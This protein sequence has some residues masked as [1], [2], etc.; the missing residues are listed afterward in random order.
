MSKRMMSDSQ[1]DSGLKS[2][3][4]HRRKIRAIIEQECDGSRMSSTKWKEMLN[5]LWQTPCQYRVKLLDREKPG[6][7]GWFSH[8]DHGKPGEA[9]KIWVEGGFSPLPILEVEW[10]EIRPTSLKKTDEYWLN[11]IGQQLDALQVPHTLEG[12]TIRVTGHV[13]RPAAK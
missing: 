6:N 4:K 12:E 9:A 7:W 13:R 11:Q 2:I 5:A 1:E 3:E 8:T 10:V